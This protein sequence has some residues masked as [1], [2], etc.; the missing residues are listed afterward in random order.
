[1]LH[2][3]AAVRSPEEGCLEEGIL[4]EVAVRWSMVWGS[5]DEVEEETMG[6][7]CK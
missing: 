5:E 7:K 3:A 6:D 4:E 2:Q 1:M